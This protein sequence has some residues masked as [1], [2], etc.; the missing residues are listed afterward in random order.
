MLDFIHNLCYSQTSKECENLSDSDLR[1]VLRQYSQG[2]FNGCPTLLIFENQEQMDYGQIRN[3]ELFDK[4]RY[5]C[6]L[7]EEITEDLLIRLKYST[8]VF[9]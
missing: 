2:I 1:D 3:I 7:R 4:S 9:V 6:Y 8:F 5:I